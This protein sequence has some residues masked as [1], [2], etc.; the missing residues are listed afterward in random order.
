MA[1]DLFGGLGGLVKGLSGFMPQ[2]DPNVKLFGAQTE[3]TDLKKQQQE[4]YAEIGKRAVSKYGIESFGELSDKLRL[5][6]NNIAA[7]EEKFNAM[8]AEK[9][10]KEMAEQERTA[11]RTCPS[12]GIQN[13]EGTKFCQECGTKLGAKEECFCTSCGAK[14]ALGTRFCGEC[15][16]R[17]EG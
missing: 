2:D 17:Q 14:L 7:A 8:Q 9:N 15:G 10:A 12:C 3:L 11:A 16:A 6:E 5:V 13:P 1:S 4:L